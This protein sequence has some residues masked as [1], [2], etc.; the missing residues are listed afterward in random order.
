MPSDLDDE[1]F[2]YNE[3]FVNKSFKPVLKCLLQCMR[4]EKAAL[5][6]IKEK[7]YMERLLQI[8]EEW[9]DDEVQ[10]MVL[11]TLKLIFMSDAAFDIVIRDYPS[12]GQFLALMID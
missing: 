5:Q 4:N 9:S 12:M 11:R 8:A 3:N 6:F 7:P 1:T 10:I 2:E